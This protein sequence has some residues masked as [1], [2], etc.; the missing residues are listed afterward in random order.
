MLSQQQKQQKKTESRKKMKTQ[1]IYLNKRKTPK[2]RKKN[3]VYKHKG[4]SVFCVLDKRLGK[5]RYKKL[6]PKICKQK[7]K[8]YQ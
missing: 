8:L 2:E 3:D 5:Q 4:H 7:E 1:K 6:H